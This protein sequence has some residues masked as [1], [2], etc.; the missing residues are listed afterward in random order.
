VAPLGTAAPFGTA[1]IHELVEVSRVAEYICNEDD[2]WLAP[3]HSNVISK[4]KTDDSRTNINQISIRPCD[5]SGRSS[6]HD[7]VLI[8]CGQISA[9]CL[10]FPLCS[11]SQGANEVC[12]PAPQRFTHRRIRSQ[13]PAVLEVGSCRINIGL[14]PCIGICWAHHTGFQKQI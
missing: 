13:H 3:F 10:R 5:S 2:R 6:M 4:G 1:K 14:R 8:V 9:V 12:I 11:F 7:K